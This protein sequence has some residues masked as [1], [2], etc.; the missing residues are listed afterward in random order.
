MN[1][2]A[3]PPLAEVPSREDN[4][5]EATT[6]IAG[7]SEANVSVTA[8]VGVS[9]ALMTRMTLRL[10]PHS[11]WR[12]SEWPDM[13]KPPL[14]LLMELA[15]RSDS[16]RSISSGQRSFAIAEPTADRQ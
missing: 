6:G 2:S 14:T 15:P 13:A 7:Y 5:S 8:G 10:L 11:Q 1:T 12:S 16:L 4:D 3:I 9:D